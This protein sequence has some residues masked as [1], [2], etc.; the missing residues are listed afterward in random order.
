MTSLPEP[1]YKDDLATLYKGKA[2]DIL[3]LLNGETI[4]TSP[5][6]NVGIDYGEGAPKDT[7]SRDEYESLVSQW[8]KAM[9]VAVGSQGR[10]FVNVAPVVSM[11]NPAGPGWHSGHCSLPRLP[12]SFIWQSALI[13]AGFDVRDVVAWASVRGQGTAWGSYESPAAPNIRGDHENVIVAHTGSWARETPKEHKGWKD[14]NGGWVKLVSNVWE[15]QPEL[16]SASPHPAPFPVD[17]PV[18]CIRLGSWPGE[19]VI[20]PFAGSGTTLR[21]A[22]SLGRKS[23][24]IE[25]S[26]TWCD[27]IASRLAQQVMVF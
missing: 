18:A 26:E 13:E 9:A 27:L 12:L 24:G 17:L 1:F 6:Y 8:A 5:P 14:K 2:E 4:V 16:A 21:V 25:P 19:T 20:D 10:A 15:F 3:P 11:L 7:F 22:T 23:I